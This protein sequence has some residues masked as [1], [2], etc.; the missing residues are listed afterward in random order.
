LIHQSSVRSS[1]LRSAWIVLGTLALAGCAGQGP[2]QVFGAAQP[3]GGT[4]RLT[5]PGPVIGKSSGNVAL[6]VPLT[7]TL[8]PYGQALENAAKL[9]FPAGSSPSLDVRDTGGTPQ[10]A[11]AA[12]Q[13]AIAAGDGII[14]GPLTS[15]EA[16]AVAPIA[17]AAGV[18]MLSFTN[19]STVAAPGIWALGIT[20][21]QQVDRVMQ[22]AADKGRTQV[23]ALLPD[24]DFGRRLSDEISAESV[25]LS[26]PSP[27]IVFYDEDFHSVNR[28]VEQISD[29]ASR[30]QM[31]ETEI[32]Q[33]RDLDTNAGRERAREL[34]HQQ[35]PPPPFNALF[36]GAT[37]GDT[38]AEFA[39]FLP[40]Y[41]VNQP[42]VQF[43]GPALW[44]PLAVQ[45]AH[46]PV[47]MGAMYAAPD[48]AVASAFNTKYQVTYGAP[49]PAIADLAFDAAAIAKLAASSGGYT[50][51]V[52]T[53]PAGFTGTD[54]AL[55]LQP[56]GQVLR[57]LAVFQVAPGAPAVVA[58]PPE[59]L[60]QPIS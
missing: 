40:Y 39:N 24:T 31:I 16:H 21:M 15:P 44:A 18:N 22:V 33:A 36:I 9:V 29:F 59:R 1:Y 60:N 35:I 51:P 45:M 37:R 41:D 7:G 6:L 14:L 30:G 42:Q 55:V 46:Q 58:P 4:A 28:A 23:A 17:Q 43:L 12:A 38:L 32:K 2:G 20:P 11:A 3:L 8:A 19:D 27:Q 34:E 48:P 57:G 13:A 53:A 56:N 49:P 25:R 26:E 54:G 47:L 52:L 50:T 10:G 5:A